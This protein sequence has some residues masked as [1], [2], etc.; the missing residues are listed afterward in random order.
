MHRLYL[1]HVSI[2]ECTP[3]GGLHP[4]VGSCPLATA[5]AVVQILGLDEL[6]ALLNLRGFK[7][8]K[9]QVACVNHAW[10]IQLAVKQMIAC[11]RADS[12]PHSLLCLK[13]LTADSCGISAEIY[14]ITLNGC[15]NS[16]NAASTAC[17]C[18]RQC[19]EARKATYKPSISL[20][21]CILIY[22]Q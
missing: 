2:L 12:N 18:P 14:V 22:Y 10:E 21:L 8:Y 9:V 19:Q 15:S 11:C 7:L 17:L 5:R 4:H 6:Q 13:L 20:D 3:T 16:S 1:E